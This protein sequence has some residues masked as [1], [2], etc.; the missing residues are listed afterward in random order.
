[1][2]IFGNVVATGSI[3]LLFMVPGEDETVRVNGRACVT[4]NPDILSLW[5]GELRRPKVA[6]GIEVVEVFNHC[7]K[8]FR[9]GGLWDPQ[10]WARP[11]DGSGLLETYADRFATPPAAELRSLL[12]T[13][14]TAVLAAEREGD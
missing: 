1:M 10:S 11:V 3:G 12:E 8:A 7:P 5:E 4:V 9:R 13:D 6:V 2:E 14:Y